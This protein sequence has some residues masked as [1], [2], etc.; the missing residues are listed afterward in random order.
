MGNTSSKEMSQNTRLE[1][2]EWLLIQEGGKDIIPPPLMVEH[3]AVFIPP[4]LM[5]EHP[6][7]YK[8]QEEEKENIR[9]NKL[10]EDI[11]THYQNKQKENTGNGYIAYLKQDRGRIA[12]NWIFNLTGCRQEDVDQI[13]G[14]DYQYLIL[15]KERHPETGKLHHVRGF[16]QMKNRVQGRYLYRKIHKLTCFEMSYS[17]PELERTFYRQGDYEEYGVL[18][19]DVRNKELVPRDCR[20]T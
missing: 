7:E 17:T 19:P 14:S 11:K 1:E 3:P 13:I 20:F 5:E 6:V 2:T 9:P 8:P 12:N 16:I 4:P 10:L 18:K 15:Q